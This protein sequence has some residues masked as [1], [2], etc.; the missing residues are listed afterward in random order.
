MTLTDILSYFFG[1]I[2]V[3]LFLYVLLGFFF[4]NSSHEEFQRN[5]SR[6]ID[7]FVAVILLTV[8]LTFFLSL[9]IGQST[10]YFS[11]TLPSQIYE[12]FDNSWSLL[13]VGIVI[14]LLYLFIYLFR[15]PMTPFTKP[16]TIIFLE[17]GS[18]ILFSILLIVVVVRTFF[19]VDLVA[20]FAQYWEEVFG[21]SMPVTTP[22]TTDMSGNAIVGSGKG[23]VVIQTTA[24]V[25]Q[26]VST[27]T[28]AGDNSHNE[29]F[30]VSGNQFTYT[31]APAVC[32]A[33]GAKLAT[34]DQVEEAYNKGAEW[35][36]YGWSANQMAFF[37]T[38]KKTWQQLQAN[39][40]AAN[41]CGRP[42]VNGGYMGNPN[43]QFG[44]NCY[45]KKPEMTP[46]DEA[47]MEKYQAALTQPTPL[48]PEEVEF[49]RKL[50]YWQQNAAKLLTINGFNENKWSEY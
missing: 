15:I 1:F 6:S 39:P 48:T 14:F 4:K 20:S 22:V 5:L 36:N 26:N 16:F 11:E 37:P 30:N 17:S 43:L 35:C 25:V 42:G 2:I 27:A 34:Y 8:G 23:N 19:K 24:S 33:M 38:Q 12:F 9:P 18:W 31:E 28:A 29:V 46:A 50:K 10:N 13:T 3:Y 49:E 45:G 47:Q 21:H 40:S 41:N 32:S 44:V 7:T